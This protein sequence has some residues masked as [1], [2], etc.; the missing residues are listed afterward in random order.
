MSSQS[1]F[2]PRERMLAAYEGRFFDCVPVTPK[3]YF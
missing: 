3:L 2:T 1:A